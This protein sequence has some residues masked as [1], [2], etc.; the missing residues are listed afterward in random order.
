MKTKNT[1]TAAKR[2]QATRLLDANLDQYL[3]L[4]VEDVRREASNELGFKLATYFVRSFLKSHP[5][6]AEIEAARPARHDTERRR[7]RG[8]AR[9]AVEIADSLLNSL[10]SLGR[11]DPMIISRVDDL[12]IAFVD[13]K[14]TTNLRRPRTDL[15]KDDS[16]HFPL[17]D[18]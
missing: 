11:F 17:G 8:S 2:F 16:D 4:S 9:D 1:I 15:I 5:R 12:R 7:E 10:A 18:C 14:L 13:S 3:G 6:S